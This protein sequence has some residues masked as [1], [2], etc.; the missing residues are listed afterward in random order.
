M[1]SCLPIY[2]VV[3]SGKALAAFHSPWLSDELLYTINQANLNGHSSHIYVHDSAYL[4][5]RVSLQN[6][7]YI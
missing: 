3:N 7:E 4:E 2:V 1:T 6:G 5:K